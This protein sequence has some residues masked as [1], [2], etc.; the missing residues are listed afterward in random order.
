[1]IPAGPSISQHPAIVISGLQQQIFF[2]TTKNLIL[3]CTASGSPVP[4]YEITI[5]TTSTTNTTTTTTTTSTTQL[6][7]GVRQNADRQQNTLLTRTHAHIPHQH[8]YKAGQLDLHT[9][10]FRIK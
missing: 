7:V 6:Q 2:T 8:Q 9:A 10:M 3:S 1:M 4:R 5:C